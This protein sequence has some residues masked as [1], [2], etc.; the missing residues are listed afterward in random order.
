MKAKAAQFSRAGSFLAGIFVHVN[1][2]K[3]LTEQ[4]F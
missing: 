2:A 4:A 3:M 1:L